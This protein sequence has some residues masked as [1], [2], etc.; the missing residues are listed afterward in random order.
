MNTSTDTLN[1][2]ATADNNKKII[3]TVI[4][5]AQPIIAVIKDLSAIGTNLNIPKIITEANDIYNGTTFVTPSAHTDQILQTANK[6]VKS[7]ITVQIIPTY[8][9]SNPTGTTFIIGD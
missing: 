6:I 9:T 8:E 5:N 2:Y 7:N 1:L 3:S 4:S